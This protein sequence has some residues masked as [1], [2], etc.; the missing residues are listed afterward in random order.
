MSTIRIEWL[1]KEWSGVVESVVRSRVKIS[2]K[3]TAGME[4]PVIYKRTTHQALIVS[5]GMYIILKH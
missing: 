2:G 5:I 3:L 4:V 1:E